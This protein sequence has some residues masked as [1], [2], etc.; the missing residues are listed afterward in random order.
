M[1][2][3]RAAPEDPPPREVGKQRRV[4]CNGGSAFTRIFAGASSN[5]HRFSTNRFT[6]ALRGIVPG[7]QTGT[8]RIPA[9]EPN[10][11]AQPRRRPRAYAVPFARRHVG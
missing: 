7:P 6:A 11:S 10:I 5:G 4:A 1:N 2:W 3:Q 9:V 8:C